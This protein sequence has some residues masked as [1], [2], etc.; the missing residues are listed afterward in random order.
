MMNIVVSSGINGLDA[1]YA[2]VTL[3]I[4]SI[5]M[6]LTA[7]SPFIDRGHGFLKIGKKAIVLLC[8]GGL[9]ANGLGWILM[10]Y[11]FLFTSETTAVPISSTSPLFAALAGFLFFREKATLLTI[12]GVISVVAEIIIIFMV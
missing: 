1:N 6:L 4:A 3:R 8:A 12:L 5:A 7:F 11:S 2:I 10:N 9:I